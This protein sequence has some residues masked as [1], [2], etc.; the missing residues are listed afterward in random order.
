MTSNQPSQPPRPPLVRLPGEISRLI[1]SHPSNRDIKNLRLVSSFFD[2]TAP[3]RLDRVFIS[4]DPRNLEVFEAVSQHDVYRAQITEVV[5][6]DALLASSL[7][8]H[9]PSA[10]N[11]V[12]TD[13]I[14]D[15]SERDPCPKWYSKACEENI[16]IWRSM[17]LRSWRKSRSLAREPQF[18]TTLMSL[19][20]SWAYYQGLLRQQQ[21]VLDTRAHV[22]AL[23]SGIS[24]FPALRKITI[25]GVAHGR[26]FTP[27]YETPMIRAFPNGFNYAIPSWPAYQ[28]ECPVWT[29]S[30]RRW[31]GFR[32]VMNLLAQNLDGGKVTELN[33]KSF[34]L[35]T[36]L[37][38]RFFEKPCQTLTNLE[39]V[40]GRASFESLHLDLMVHHDDFQAH[41]FDHNL[42]KRVLA[43]TA[44]GQGLK[45]LALGASV[46]PWG[47]YVPLETIYGPNNLRRLEHFNLSRLLVK[48]KDLL[49]LLARMP[50]SIRTIELSFLD[51]LEGNYQSLLSQIKDTLGWQNRDPR[52]LMSIGADT[53]LDDHGVAIWAENEVYSFLYEGGVNP[54]DH[55]SMLYRDL[56]LGDGLGIVKDALDPENRWPNLSHQDLE[57]IG[58]VRN[59]LC[60]DSFAQR[61]Q[62]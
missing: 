30:G 59:L 20:D 40:L 34:Q 11:N 27:V 26:L 35:R 4:A 9:D 56:C 10:I 54:F 49:A 53:Q 44:R 33:I 36:G 37:N 13:E 41:V 39:M 52:P 48:E 17:L 47:F 12:I 16:Q 32:V 8:E 23:E 14:D 31:E 50:L 1:Y 15:R 28:P 57:E 45:K 38:C 29:E 62:Y 58:Y 22:R 5:W 6:D 3:L 61:L 42:L 2:R 60:D 24:R 46:A 25:T 55:D 21:E 18:V 7:L 51:F 19:K 43:G